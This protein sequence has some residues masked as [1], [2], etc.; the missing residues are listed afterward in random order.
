MKSGKIQATWNGCF[1]VLVSC[2]LLMTAS[3]QS[4]VLFDSGKGYETYRIPAIVRSTKGTFLAFAEGRESQRDHGNIDIVLRRSKDDGKTWDEMSVVRDDG[5]N[6]VGNPCPFVDE[7]SGRILLMYCGSSFSEGEVLNGKGAREVYI[8]HS[9][10]DGHSWSDPRN[11]SPMV[12]MPDWRWYATGPCSGIQISSGKHAGRLVVPANHSIHYDDGEKWEYRCHSVYSD[13][14]GV[15]W[16]IGESSE[17]GASETQIA[18]AGTGLLI[19]DIRMQTHR[20]GVRALRFSEDGG[21]SWSPLKHDSSRFD[22]K[23]QGSVIS[24]L[25]DGSEKRKL[26]SSNPSSQKGRENLTAYESGDGGA[27]WKKL[28]ALHQGPSAYS[29]LVEIGDGKFACLFEAGEISPYERIVFSA[30]D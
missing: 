23:C 8:V 6:Q 25:L 18:E 13:D 17:P 22:P 19:Q 11:I 9:D 15:T 12:K 10:D 28:V 27:T 26:I 30:I 29:D 1:R 20:K 3:A 24:V 4:Q 5:D 16:K 21:E 14:F 2:G 7:K